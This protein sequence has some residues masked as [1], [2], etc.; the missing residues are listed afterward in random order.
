MTKKGPLGKAE[1]YYVEGHCDEQDAKQIAKD[2]D[3]PI[4]TVKKHIDKVKKENPQDHRLTAG[5][6]MARQEGVVIM[7]ENASSV[8]DTRGR[9]KNPE[10]T[11]QCTVSIKDE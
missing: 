4:A 5:K 8:S 11:R 6:Q 10:R 3:R 7:T 9:G 1:I 2:L